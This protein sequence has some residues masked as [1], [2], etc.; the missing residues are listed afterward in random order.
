VK[1]IGGDPIKGLLATP[2]SERSDDQQRALLDHFLSTRDKPYQQLAKARRDLLKQE[3]DLK[4][5]GKVTSMIMQDN[6]A[7]K[8]RATYVLNRGQYDQPIKE[9]EDAVVT[10]GVPKSLF[11][12]PEGAGSN[13][14]GLA[15]WLTDPGHPLTARVAV[16]RYWATLF[17]RGLVKTAGDFGN[18]GSPPSHPELLDWL[19]VDFVESGWDVK[20]MIKQIV[21]SQT[22]RQSARVEPS[23][24]EA[25]PENILLG[26]APR[27]RLK[28]EFIRDGALAVSGLLVEKLGGPSV[29]PYQPAN[30]WN[31]VSLNGGLRYGQDKGEKLYRRSMYTYWKRSA[32]MPNMLIFDAP[33]REKCTIQRPT[34]NTPLQA[35]V[36]LN[37]PQFVEAA[38]AFAQRVIKES[39]AA[40]KARIDRAFRLAL[41]RSASDREVQILTRVLAEQR[42]KFDADPE[43]AKQLLATGESP[44][45]E[46][47]P[48]AEHA[49][50]TVLAQMVLNMD[51]ALTRG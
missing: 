7:N 26:R 9:G 42:G 21:T 20:R 13:R 50:W 10:P 33:S 28:G 23:H 31:E 49:A 38:R 34:T 47:I 16:N 14:L 29:K 4:T 25:D 44:R 22:Y 11:P 45:D 41:A 32:P 6:P 48:A 17:G 24:L 39:G 36:A 40:P 3:G 15:K 18:Q 1:G 51:E 43:R 27:P 35:L 5:K 2:A 12:M 30:I 19:A 37:D 8:L 46:S